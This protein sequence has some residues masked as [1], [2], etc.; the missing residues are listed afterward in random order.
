[1]V[2]FGLRHFRL[3][4]VYIVNMDLGLLIVVVTT[5][6]YI[7][8]MAIPMGIAKIRHISE[9]HKNSVAILCAISIFV[10]PVWFAALILSTVWPPIDR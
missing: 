8:F 7:L 1:M 2:G 3:A 5:L 6:L 4:S 9:D 10:P